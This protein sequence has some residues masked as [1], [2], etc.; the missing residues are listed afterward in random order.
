[1]LEKSGKC[2]R[3]GKVFICSVL[4]LWCGILGF[5][6]TAD[7]TPNYFTFS[8][9]EYV[10]QLKSGWNLGN[11]LDSYGIPGLAAE[12]YWGLPKA[13][14]ELFAE[15]KKAGFSTVRIPVSWH[16][17]V[18]AEYEIETEWMNRV[19][20]V[21]D[22]ALD[23]NLFVI[24]NCHHDCGFFG[25]AGYSVKTFDIEKS[26]KYLTSIWQQ[27][28]ATFAAY[29]GRLSFE[30]LNEPRLVGESFEWEWNISSQPLIEAAR[31]INE[32]SQCCLD[33]IRQSGQNNALRFVLVTSYVASPYA[34]AS[35]VF[36]LPADTAKD[37]LILSTHVYAPYR[38]AMDPKG[39]KSFGVNERMEIEAL[40]DTLKNGVIDR[41][42]VPVVITEF[43]AVNKNNLND[44]CKWLECFLANARNYGIATVVWDNGNAYSKNGSSEELF[45]LLDRNK[46]KWHFNKYT[47]IMTAQ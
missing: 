45:G 35:T 44:R 10:A 33:A 42:N 4:V 31:T 24:L 47:K 8:S 37:K 41:F 17:H 12:T 19:K 46:L 11:T 34:A 3:F 39:I 36:A 29:D 26:E 32:L 23:Q 20:N 40:M 16:D 43:G 25:D 14:A 13:T 15:I 18:N 30:L 22:M 1:M 6:Q 9:F 7:S 5:A 27:I 21:V 28:A 38:F 2:T